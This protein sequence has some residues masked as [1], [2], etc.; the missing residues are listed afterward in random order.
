[1]KVKGE[2]Q[3]IECR[4]AEPQK[5]RSRTNSRMS[6]HFRFLF[7]AVLMLVTNIEINCHLDYSN[8]KFYLMS[9]KIKRIVFLRHS[10]QALSAT[11]KS[12]RCFNKKIRISPL[13]F[14]SAVLRFD[15][16][17]SAVQNILGMLANPGITAHCKSSV[18][19]ISYIGWPK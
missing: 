1:M 19:D 5:L 8:S 3:N 7:L 12:K 15:I 4:T 2:P 6:N 10:K 11:H 17:Y 18:N 16:R 13:S 9:L 14:T